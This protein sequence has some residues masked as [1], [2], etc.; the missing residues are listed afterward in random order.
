MQNIPENTTD[1]QT[2]NKPLL[3]ATES[4]VTTLFWNSDKSK[5][6]T[7][8]NLQNFWAKFQM[9]AIFNFPESSAISCTTKLTQI[10]AMLTNKKQQRHNKH[11][12]I[13]QNSQ[14]IR[15]KFSKIEPHIPINDHVS[16]IDRSRFKKK[17][18]KHTSI[19]P[20]LSAQ[21]ENKKRHTQATVN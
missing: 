7:D 6:I 11:S 18:I 9:E 2:L 5:V 21:F 3:N 20:R 15:L 1:L 8:T 12:K 16:L 19:F 10:Y 4:S 17:T 13:H 14:S